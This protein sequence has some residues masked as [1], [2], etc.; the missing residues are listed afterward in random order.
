MLTEE[1][2]DFLRAE[3]RAL[4]KATYT[5]V[6]LAQGTRVT[7]VHEGAEAM[8]AA[9]EM[10]P[11]E[12]EAEDPPPDP[13]PTQ[14]GLQRYWIGWNHRPDYGQFSLGGPWWEDGPWETPIGTGRFLVSVVRTTSEEET[15]GVVRKSYLH[16]YPVDVEFRFCDWRPDGWSPFTARFPRAGWME[17]P[18]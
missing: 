12:M 9:E 2:K 8:L 6:L 1:E 5:A 4:R 3:F 15:M 13:V 10:T 7:K 16:E 14:D 11:E 17:W 18:T